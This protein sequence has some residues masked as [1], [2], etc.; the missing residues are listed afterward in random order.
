MLF[1]NLDKFLFLCQTNNKTTLNTF[2]CL[3]YYDFFHTF[4]PFIDV[5]ISF[6]I[7]AHPDF[8]TLTMK[9]QFKNDVS[10]NY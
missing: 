10:G 3:F 4:Q 8:Q 9:I 2:Y 6:L 1:Y 7:V 5:K